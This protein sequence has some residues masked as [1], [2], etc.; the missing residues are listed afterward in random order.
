MKI[1]Q[2]VTKKEYRSIEVRHYCAFVYYV[3]LVVS[4]TLTSD[5]IKIKVDYYTRKEKS[6]CEIEGLG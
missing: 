1:V 4:V 2:Y 6:K 3:I 5:V